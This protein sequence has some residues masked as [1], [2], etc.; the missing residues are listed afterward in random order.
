[1]VDYEI[2]GY[3]HAVVVFVKE[4]RSG[5]TVE[6]PQKLQNTDLVASRLVDTLK[7]NSYFM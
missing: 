5:G 2:K 7:F 3:L 4:E 1:M 6:R